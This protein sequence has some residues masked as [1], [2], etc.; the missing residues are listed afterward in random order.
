MASYRTVPLNGTVR[1]DVHGT[2]DLG[3]SRE[4]LLDIARDAHLN[5]RGLLIDLRDALGALSYRDVHNLVGVLVEHPDTFRQRVA[6]LEDHTER[7]EKAQFFEA[8][9]TERGFQVRAFV[10]EAQAIAWLEQNEG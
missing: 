2:L 10:D 1:L 8:Y 5:G 6:L 7:F 4:L 3:A 9:A